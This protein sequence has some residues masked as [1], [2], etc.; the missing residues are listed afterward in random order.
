[1]LNKEY[2]YF[3]S[4]ACFEEYF[5]IFAKGEV[6]RKSDLTRT[7]FLQTF[8]NKVAIGKS[9]AK[10]YGSGNINNHKR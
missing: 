9:N 6:A 5:P 10:M 4:T 3:N 8:I 1:M 7:V 2:C